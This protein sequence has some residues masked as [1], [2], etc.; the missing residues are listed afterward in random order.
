M[1]SLRSIPRSSSGSPASSRRLDEN[2]LDAESTRWGVDDS[3][4]Y[5]DFSVCISVRR[6]PASPLT[7]RA[8]GGSGRPG[9]L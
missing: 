8:R 1:T 3:S 2:Y 7:D 6:L 4:G 9:A 5:L